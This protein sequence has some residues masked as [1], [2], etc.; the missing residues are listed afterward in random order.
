MTE[1]FDMK[2]VEER[3][4]LLA[5]AVRDGDDTASSVDELE[6]LVRT[7]GAVTVDKMIQNR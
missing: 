4:I 2:D 7:A 5:V 3:V 6:E 1:L